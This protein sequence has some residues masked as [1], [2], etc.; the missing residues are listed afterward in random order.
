MELKSNSA[1]PIGQIQRLLE[2]LGFEYASAEDRRGFLNATNKCRES[3]SCYL[4]ERAL[5]TDLGDW[6]NPITQEFF[7]HMAMEFTSYDRN[8]EKFWS[9]TRLLCSSDLV[10]PWD[11]DK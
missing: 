2:H 9:F 11:K 7:G 1:P 4:A 5:Q 8:G 3:S 6:E 10:F